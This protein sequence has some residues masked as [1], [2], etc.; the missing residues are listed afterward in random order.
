MTGAAAS[1]VTLRA[2]QVSDW[3][4]IAALL[5]DADLPLAGAREHLDD[6]IVAEGAG[7]TALG[8]AA[9]ERYPAAAGAGASG[10]L[11]SLAV[12]PDA[13]GLGLGTLLVQRVLDTARAAGLAD[14]T[15]LT[16]TAANY[17]PR[18]DFRVIPRDEAPTPV[19]D[20]LE[21][22]EA[23]PDSATVMTRAI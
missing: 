10:L 19:R 13:H 20:S 16:T 5:A 15:L 7:G 18:F 2:A 14:V 12:A 1:S 8:C 4:A 22:R 21:F 11:R 3:L 17:F 6:F 9:L 23:C